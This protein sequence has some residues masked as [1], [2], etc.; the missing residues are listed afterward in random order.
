MTRPVSGNSASQRRLG[1]MQSLTRPDMK[2]YMLGVLGQ[3]NSRKLDVK[4]I[5]MDEFLVFRRGTIGV[6][7][8]TVLVEC[9]FP[10]MTS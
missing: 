8:C 2:H 10:I 9:V 5:S 4:T 6:M 1:L 7:P 3:V